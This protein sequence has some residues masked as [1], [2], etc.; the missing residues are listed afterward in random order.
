[1]TDVHWVLVLAQNTEVG[2]MPEGA[3]CLLLVPRIKAGVDGRGC[4][5]TA[6]DKGV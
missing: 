5:T 6:C 2:W 4:V 3:K 1:M